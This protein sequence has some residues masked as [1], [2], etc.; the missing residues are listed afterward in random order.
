MPSEI[1]TGISTWPK[2]AAVGEQS[3]EDAD[4]RRQQENPPGWGPGLGLAPGERLLGYVL[5]DEIDPDHSGVSMLLPPMP[6]K[7][8]TKPVTQPMRRAAGSRQTPP[9]I[10]RPAFHACGDLNQFFTI[11]RQIRNKF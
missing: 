4:R 2:A 1:M 11:S 9:F 10:H 7:A 5:D 8:D 3:R 6:K